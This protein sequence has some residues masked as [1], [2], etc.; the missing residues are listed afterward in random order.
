M[1]LLSNNSR[2]ELDKH[3]F[4]L[5]VMFLVPLLAIFA[6]AYLPLRFPR[7]AVLDLPLIVTVYFAVARRNPISGTLLGTAIGLTQ[8]A[9]THLPLG[10]NGIIKAVVGYLS[11]SIG[12]RIDVDN[13][14]TRLIMLFVF[15]LLDSILH[16]FIVRRLLG[17]QQDWYWLHELIRAVVNALVGIILFTLLDRLRQRE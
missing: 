1:A 16:L 14:G 17:L 11:A 7:F 12:M 8:D 5:L 3:R 6:Q 13:P 4:P 9:L 2:E 15:T 10:I